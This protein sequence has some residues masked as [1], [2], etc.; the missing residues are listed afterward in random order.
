M[1]IAAVSGFRACNTGYGHA[2]GQFSH[3]ARPIKQNGP[4]LPSGFDSNLPCWRRREESHYS[5]RNE[6]RYLVSHKSILRPERECH[7]RQDAYERRDVIP[8]HFFVQINHGE[9]HENRQGD[10]LLDDFELRGGIDRI[11]PPIS[12]HWKAIFEERDAPAHEDDEQQRLVL[13]L[14]MAI[15][16]ERHE[17]VR[18]GQQHDR[19]PAGFGIIHAAKNEFTRERSQMGMRNFRTRPLWQA[20]SGATSL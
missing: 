4:R 16:R 6:P 13:E 11:A 2:G 20:P 12:R 17:N 15:P 8:P 9:N 18:A 19:E 5:T 14:Q 1:R 3:S 10:D 7:R